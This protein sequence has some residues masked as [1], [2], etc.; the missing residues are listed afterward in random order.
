MKLLIW[1]GQDK[2]FWESPVE[3]M[4]EAM[5]NIC[6]AHSGK[7]CI[8]GSRGKLQKDQLEER[9]MGGISGTNIKSILK[10]IYGHLIITMDK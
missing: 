8:S 5:V 1:I 4:T 10:N 6:M 3:R 2:E 9:V 7:M